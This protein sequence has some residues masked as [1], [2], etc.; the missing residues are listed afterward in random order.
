MRLNC[1]RANKQTD[2]ATPQEPSLRS[3]QQKKK[4]RDEQCCQLGGEKFTIPP[5]HC[6]ND[7]MARLCSFF[8]PSLLSLFLSRID[9]TASVSSFLKEKN[10]DFCQGRRVH[11]LG[12]SRRGYYHHHGA[13]WMHVLPTSIPQPFLR[14]TSR[15]FCSRNGHFNGFGQVWWIC[16]LFLTS[17]NKRGK[18]ISFCVIIANEIHYDNEQR[19]R[20]ETKGKHDGRSCFVWRQ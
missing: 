20:E 12:F 9:L 19:L 13:E 6:P 16:D 1:N 8:F 7:S 17:F 14:W 11:F 5:T 2:C 15:N 3:S 18:R 10:G 4:S